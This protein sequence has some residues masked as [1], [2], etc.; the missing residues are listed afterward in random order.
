MI[1][2]F[3]R[4]FFL[5][6]RNVGFQI[7]SIWIMFMDT[8]YWSFRRPIRFSHIFKQMEFI[9]VK[10]LGIV[11]VTGGFT[12]MVLALQTYYAFRAFSSEGLV[13]ATVALSMTRELGPVLTA[14]MVTGRAGSAIAAELGTMRVTEQI[15]ALTV[16]AVNPIKY[17]VVPRV[18]AGLLMLPLLTVIADFMGI[19][20]GYFVAIKL[21]GISEGNFV[22]RM[23]KYVDLEDIYNGLAKAACF[24]VILA[25]ISCYKG[26]YAKGGAEGV[27]RATTETVVMSSIT[28]LIADYVLTSLMF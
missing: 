23:I 22:N 1:S 24:G 26:F 2:N 20:G 16:M 14:L 13:G 4:N 27:G 18:L 7:G 5:P 15:D 25:V 12:G 17:L 8:V 10:S 9:G 19:V 6:L 3:L 21:L 28:I 11:I